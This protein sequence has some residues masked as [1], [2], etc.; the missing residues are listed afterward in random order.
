MKK[1][2]GIT[3]IALIITI[4]VM[5]ILV[6]VTI[7]MAVN[8]G[9]FGYAGNAAKETEV[10][11]QKET[12]LA[13]GKATITLDGHTF[14]S[15][16]ELNQY[17]QDG[18]IPVSE[19]DILRFANDEHEITEKLSY[20]GP[21]SGSDGDYNWGEASI[22]RCSLNNKL[23][24]VGT[25]YEQETEDVHQINWDGNMTFDNNGVPE[26][27]STS[28]GNYQKGNSY[29]NNGE[30]TVNCYQGVVESVTIIPPFNS[31]CLLHYDSAGLL[32]YVQWID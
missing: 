20:I 9:L 11:K 18:T 1:N 2:D 23:Y 8:G 12:E 22:Y 30:F 24:I 7:N 19:A 5:L 3:L 14:N 25:K 6:A 10:E 13:E 21:F 31:I 16:D 4:I 26:T 32:L 17:L 29:L 15:M 28:F 27:L